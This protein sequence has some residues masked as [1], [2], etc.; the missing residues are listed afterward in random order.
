MSNNEPI[1]WST[2]TPNQ[3][4][5]LIAQH[6]FGRKVVKWHPERDMFIQREGAEGH[7]NIPKYTE[8][9]DEAWKVL[10]KMTKDDEHAQDFADHFDSFGDGLRFV[11]MPMYEI[12]QWASRWTPENICIAALRVQGLTVEIEGE[13]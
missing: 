2:L 7:E 13:P 12:I 3:R 9:M 5:A 11:E 10:Q 8:S 1:Q 6:I 4:N